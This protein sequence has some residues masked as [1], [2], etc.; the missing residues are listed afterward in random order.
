MPVPTCDTSALLTADDP[1]QLYAEWRAAGPLLKGGPLQWVVTR[2]ADVARLL[3]D[4]R[5]EHR[6]PRAYLEFALGNGAVA[7]FRERS[8]LNRDGKDH[9]RLRIL[10]GKAFSAPLVRRLRGHVTELV[11]ELLEPLL[12][13]EPFDAV[14]RLANELP[15]K[16]ICELL[17]L[18]HVDR[19]EV[20]RHTNGLT[21]DDA[22]VGDAAMAWLHRY[23]VDVLADRTPDP[24]GDL[25][26]RMLAA[27][28]GDDA[29][30][31]DEIID[32]AVLLFF[33]GFETTK[34]LI[35][36]GL[37]ALDTFAAE[38]RR[39]LDAPELATVGVEEL[40]RFDGPVP[41]VAVVVVEP[42]EV[43]GRTVAAG[44]VL[45][46]MLG[47]ANHDDATFADP[48]ALDLCRQ[49]NPHVAFGGGVHHCLGSM[50]ARVEA[51]AVFRRL[52]ERTADFG[53]A[54]EPVRSHATIGRFSSVPVVARPA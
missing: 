3:R 40:L 50:L 41:S 18:H 33:A 51:D 9:T 16:V 46:L 37:V 14:P 38:R 42:L 7:D 36:S 2:H 6:M 45:H 39:L 4:R 1:F 29:L 27:E 32:N 12:D 30:T 20:T 31:H 43:G 48:D 54:A 25:L 34:H 15:A 53:L 28:A 26:Q 44:H 35:A 47:C 19:D 49:P 13:G 17:D 23:L 10:M 24:D 5:V 21:S 22:T 11:D 52:A 8:L